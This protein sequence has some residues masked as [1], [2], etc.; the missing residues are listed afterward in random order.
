MGDVA[1]TVP[2]IRALS[3]Q[4]PT[5]KI[6]M[7]SRAFFKPFFENIPNVT[8]F[9]FDDKI[10]HKSFLGL[11][12]LFW[13][14]HL[15]KPDFFVDFHNVLRTKIIGFLFRFTATKTTIID[16]KREEK[17]AITAKVKKNFA[18]IETVFEKQVNALKRIGFDIDLS[19]VVYPQKSILSENTKSLFDIDAS[20]KL[21]GIAPFAQY[22]SKVYPLDLMQIV[23]DELAKHTNY[24][25]LLFGGGKSEILLLDALA[26]KHKNVK[27]VAGKITFKEEL[28]LISKLDLMLSMDSGN[29][30]IAAMLGVNVVT[31]WG[32]THPFTGFMPFGQPIENCITA[33]RDVFPQLPTSV[34]G[35]KTV[36]GYEDAMRTILP[37]NVVC[38]IG[39]VLQLN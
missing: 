3:L 29:A 27:V 33:D 34:Y 2:A 6:T 16:K 26:N 8:F 17:K 30:H 9:E 11:L 21:I 32:A 1:M 36:E 7:V 4:Y 19:N 28:S 35:N 31:L 38:K 25:V 20:K 13:E 37:S 23:V 15:L 39:E 14:L 5:A 10:K 24:S 18:P 12:K 22:Q